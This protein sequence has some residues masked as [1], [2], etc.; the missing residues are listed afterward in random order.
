MQL[1]K[2]Q[3][4]ISIA[5]ASLGAV[6][7]SGKAIL[8]KLAYR[9]G[10]TSEVFLTLRMAMAF[11]IFWLVY[12]FSKERIGQS[13][14]SIKEIFQVAGLG[15]C[16]Y[17]FSSYVD[18]LGL[19]YISVGLERI[20]L[21]LTPA[22][23]VIFSYFI[24]KKK[25]TKFQWISMIVGYLGVTMAFFHDAMTNG[26]AAW[27]GMGLVFLSACLYSGYLIFAGEIVKKVGSIRLVTFA[28]SF[29]VLFSVIQMIF[30]QPQTMLEQVPN[31]YW[32]SLINAAV[33]TVIPMMFIML[34]VRR[35][36]SALT[37]QAGI[38][39]P[40]STI[41]M[42]WYFLGEEITFFQ[43]CGLFLVVIAMWLLMSS[44]N[45]KLTDSD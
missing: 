30:H 8:I 6:L 3:Y 12:F 20:I 43:I 7:F 11:P 14:L 18:F 32:L 31:V 44:Q 29:S 37:S 34:S 39:G 23:V 10:T 22:I 21:Y 41:F 27:I 35:I 13:K 45:Q 9:Y 16:G 1:S 15:F 33:C 38:L 4:Y 5:M 36:G 42:G 19:H 28:S 24:L 17:F 25:I 2:K 26:Q 40:L